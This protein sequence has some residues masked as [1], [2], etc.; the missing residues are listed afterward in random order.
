M[1]P[2]STLRKRRENT[3]KERFQDD[4]CQMTT[5]FCS[6]LLSALI[7]ILLATNCILYKLYKADPRHHF[8]ALHYMCTRTAALQYS[9]TRTRTAFRAD[10]FLEEVKSE[11]QLCFANIFWSIHCRWFL[12]VVTHSVFQLLL[13]LFNLPQLCFHKQCTHSQSHTYKA[14]H[15][16]TY[17]PQTS[18][19]LFDSIFFPATFLCFA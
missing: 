15:L 13:S 14:S 19:Y 6:P 11:A 10:G 3:E 7:C 18:S 8:F 2:H 16:A 5:Y 4:R 9:R 17:L 12:T 1:C